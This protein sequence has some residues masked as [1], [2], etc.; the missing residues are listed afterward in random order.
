MKTGGRNEK[1]LTGESSSSSQVVD[2]CPPQ[3]NRFEALQARF[4]RIL[5]KALEFD[6]S[7][8][9]TQ[10]FFLGVTAVGL[11]IWLLFSVA[12]LQ[13]RTD[14]VQDYYA[15]RAWMEGQSI[16]GEEVLTRAQQERGVSF[17]NFHPPF[18]ILLFLPLGYLT[19][20]TA[21]LLYSFI[22]LVIH[23]SICWMVVRYLTNS[24]SLF[25]PVLGLS[26]ISPI[27]NETTTQGNTSILMAGGLIASWR[28]LQLGHDKRAGVLL[29][30]C[31]LLK[32]FPL[33]FGLYLLVT[34]R[35][36]ALVS[37]GISLVL[38][39]VLCVLVIGMNDITLYVTER[40]GSNVGEYG[41]HGGNLGL[42]GMIRPFLVSHPENV[43]A[44][45]VHAPLFAS[46]VVG[47]INLCVVG[48]LVREG[49]RLGREQSA[50]TLLYSLYL[51]G[52]LL[53]SPIV[54][55]HSFEV[56]LLPF[57]YLLITAKRNG[58]RV[59]VLLI[60]LTIVLTIT[61]EWD[62]AWQAAQLVPDDVGLPYWFFIVTTKVQSTGLVLLFILLVRRCRRIRLPHGE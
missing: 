55:Q 30:V 39:V 56:L 16:Y 20:D 45:I 60:V 11:L 22:G 38:C 53:V 50:H 41:F 34:R 62:R 1:A 25:I 47:V 28:L 31:G 5:T 51:V 3:K 44:P 15:V 57:L 4:D 14:F 2:G 21:Y 26:I 19:Y 33:L 43:I 35:W 9:S 58:W 10:R 42:S 8:R 61:S 54:W 24:T 36:T 13:R 18:S 7:S 49:L 6:W 27:F 40:M 59:E 32:M 48:L 17:P 23:T 12:Y 29:A 46:F 52:M 37:F